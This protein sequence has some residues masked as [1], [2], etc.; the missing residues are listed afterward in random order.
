MLTQY[1]GVEPYR[2]AKRD[3]GPQAEA[4]APHLEAG[5]TVWV[6]GP[7]DLAGKH[8]SL[9]YYLDRP[10]RAFRP[11]H[12]LL[13]DGAHCLLTAR[14]LERLAAEPAFAFH[15]TARADHAWFSYRVGVCSVAS[16]TAPPAAGD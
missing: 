14:D 6:L 4:L 5:E 11:E 8:S 13:E 2:A 16:G 7:A 12:E 1:L 15:E 9:F 10:V 3:L